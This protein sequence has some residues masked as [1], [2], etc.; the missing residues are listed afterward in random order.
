MPRPWRYHRFEPQR[1]AFSAAILRRKGPGKSTMR[2]MKASSLFVLA[3]A[4]LGSAGLLAQS[5]KIA[6]RITSY[7]NESSRTTLKGNVPHLARAEFDQG[8]ADAATQLTN[9]RLVLSRSDE[10]QAS[11]DAYLAQLQDKSS[12]NYHKWLTPQQFGELYGP[13]DSDIV[14]LVAWLESHG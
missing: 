13:A 9:M 6:P 3:G 11:L 4:L 12:P 14:A 7:V 2:S 10:Q 1:D 8:E 5:S